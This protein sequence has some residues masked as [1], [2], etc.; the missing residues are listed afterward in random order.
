MTADSTAGPAERETDD[1]P[2]GWDPIR[3]SAAWPA[4]GND[5]PRVSPTATDAA[6]PTGGGTQPVIR[7]SAWARGADA[8]GE[9]TGVARPGSRARTLMVA[10]VL[11]CVL[12]VVLA[13]FA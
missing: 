8:F 11:V 7:Q 5:D 9:P 12:A 2:K 13:I 1:R 10:V 3:V 6:A 4:I